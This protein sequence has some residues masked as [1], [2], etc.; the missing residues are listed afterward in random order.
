MLK[1]EGV[2]RDTTIG[3]RQY[4]RWGVFC[5]AASDV[6]VKFPQ[7]H[8]NKAV[9]ESVSHNATGPIAVPRS[10]PPSRTGGTERDEAKGADDITLPDVLR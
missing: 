3:S 4:P 9:L 2:S 5:N 10:L 6:S 7:E 1:H 8:S